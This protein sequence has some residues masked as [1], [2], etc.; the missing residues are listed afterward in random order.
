VEKRQY[1]RYTFREPVRY[2]LTQDLPE[3]GSLGADISDGGVR[4]R[5]QQFIPLKTI[6]NLKLH[7]KDP[8]RVVPVKGQVVWVREVPHSDVF[9]IGIRF[10][11]AHKIQ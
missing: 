3:N 9:D 8:T 4:I 6:L 5:V 11:Q 7:L 2:A 10:L 1:S